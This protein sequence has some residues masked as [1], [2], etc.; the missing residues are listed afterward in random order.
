M[1]QKHKSTL[2]VYQR[3]N[4]CD[5]INITTNDKTK[6]A[7]N[8]LL[9]NLISLSSNKLNIDM[10]EIDILTYLPEIKTICT[11]NCF[12]NITTSDDETTCNNIT[13]GNI[14]VCDGCNVFR[15]FDVI[16]H[17]INHNTYFCDH[18][19]ERERLL[20]IIDE[21]KDNINA[22]VNLGY[23]FKKYYDDYK[24]AKKYFLRLLEIHPEWGD[25]MLI[26]RCYI[27]TT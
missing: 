3:A 24:N 5:P 18:C 23:I 11:L 16:Y 15:K 1:Q 4:I 25:H 10:P 9:G 8:V 21:D 14:H 17:C 12:T 2:I 26:L 20:T 22:Y 7:I 27:K 19:F 13:S 6:I